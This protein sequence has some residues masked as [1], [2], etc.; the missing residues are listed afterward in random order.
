MGSGGQSRCFHQMPVIFFSIKF[1]TPSLK[2][3]IFFPNG[4][5]FPNP[6]NYLTCEKRPGILTSGTRT[7]PSKCPS[8]TRSW[9]PVPTLPMEDLRVKAGPDPNESAIRSKADLKWSTASS[10]SSS[11]SER[12]GLILST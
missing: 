11:A 4:N 6:T 5:F 12:A 9:A 1:S 2:K 3:G 8:S 10:R 7:P